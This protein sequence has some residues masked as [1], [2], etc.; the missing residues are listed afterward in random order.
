MPVGSNYVLKKLKL[1]AL[2]GAERQDTDNRIKYIIVR[3]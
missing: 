2:K 1:V 3:T